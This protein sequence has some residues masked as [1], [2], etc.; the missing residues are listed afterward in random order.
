MLSLISPAKS[1]NFKDKAP[2]NFSQTP[3]FEKEIYQLVKILQEL[4][5][6][7]IASL[8]SISDKLASEVY[9]KYAHF[10]KGFSESTAKQALF[11]FNGDVYRGLD[12]ATLAEKNAKFANDHLLMISGLYGLL[13]PFD[14][15]QPYRLEMGSKLDINGQSLYQF[16]RSKLT[17]Y[18]NELLSQQKTNIVINL[19]SKEYSSAFEKKSINGSWIDV[20]FKEYKQGKYKTIGIFAKRARGSMAR[21]I[22]DKEIDQVDKLIAFDR[23]NYKFNEELSNPKHLIFIRNQHS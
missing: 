15:I 17:A 2:I 4:A 6:D 9:D 13:K 1:Q 7:Q 22:I 11:T 8:M 20:D 3:K 12:A 19:A 23:E 10:K 21:F 18:L 5:P 16:W 14:L